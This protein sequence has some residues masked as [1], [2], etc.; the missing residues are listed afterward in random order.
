MAAPHSAFRQAEFGVAARKSGRCGVCMLGSRRRFFPRHA[1]PQP[2]I[3][4]I[5]TP[6]LVEMVYSS[7]MSRTNI[8]IDDELIRKAGK[9]AGLKTKRQI[10]HRALESFVKAEQRKAILQYFGSGI[11]KGDLRAMRRS[12]R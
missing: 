4:Q 10:V 1:R 12:R 6:N 2:A 11:W 8:D 5:D 9:L 3:I 7:S